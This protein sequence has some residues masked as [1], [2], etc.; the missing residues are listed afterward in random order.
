MRIA[1]IRLKDKVNQNSTRS[2]FSEM[3]T[4]F[5]NQKEIIM[6]LSNLARTLDH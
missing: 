1:V 6:R 3:K 5:F 4:Q 2:V